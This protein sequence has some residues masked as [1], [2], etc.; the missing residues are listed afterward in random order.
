MVIDP[1]PLARTLWGQGLPPRTLRLLDHHPRL[2]IAM[3]A[4]CGPAPTIRRVLGVL[5]PLVV[6]RQPGTGCVQTRHRVASH[7]R[8][9]IG[10][11]SAAPADDTRLRC[12]YVA[13]PLRRNV[14]PGDPQA[15]CHSACMMQVLLCLAAA[16]TAYFTEF[17]NS[18]RVSIPEPPRFPIPN[19]RTS[20]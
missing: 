11:A 1:P 12:R 2:L 15:R 16:L 17:P 10:R 20:G 7:D 19:T 6:S 13:A 18:S 8:M 9:V 3:A 4:C 5:L 14:A